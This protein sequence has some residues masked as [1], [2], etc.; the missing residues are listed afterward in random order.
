M[1]SRH[2]TDDDD[3]DDSS[4]Q[5]DLYGPDETKVPSTSNNLVSLFDVRWKIKHG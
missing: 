3:T 5:M 4:E 2:V 1:S